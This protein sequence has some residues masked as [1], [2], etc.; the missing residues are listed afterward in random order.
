MIFFP[1]F[2]F[3]IAT[4]S[5]KPVGN[6][7]AIFSG[8]Y[9]QH[10]QGDILLTKEQ[11]RAFTR[12]DDHIE[13]TGVVSLRYRWPKVNGKVIIPYQFEDELE[14]SKNVTLQYLDHSLSL[15]S[16]F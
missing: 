7:T 4:I 5:A 10:F 6:E 15:I 16:S 9:G 3:I 12:T 1:T 2:F 13:R 11:K 8:R 14:Y